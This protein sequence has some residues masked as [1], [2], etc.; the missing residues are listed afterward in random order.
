MWKADKLG[1]RGNTNYNRAYEGD[2]L[3]WEK[4]QPGPVPPD[5]EIW[6]T[7]TDGNIVTPTG[8]PNII[9]N[10]YENG[11]GVL[12][13][14]PSSSTFVPNG[15]WTNGYK[16][17]NLL[18]INIP[19][20]TTI[21]SAGV[22]QSCANLTTITI[23]G[24]V[25]EFVLGAGYW[26][27]CFAYSNSLTDIYYLNTMSQWN[28]IPKGRR[29]ESFISHSCIIHCIDGDLDYTGRPI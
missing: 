13:F 17:T 12:K 16:G 1:Y 6:Y 22:F 7:S 8:L 4:Q 2:E 5:N 27:Q 23:P 24:T 26:C 3:V 10:T 21:L 18:T 11:K 15:G 28:A 9:S 29:W 25:N 19:A 14:I 20:N